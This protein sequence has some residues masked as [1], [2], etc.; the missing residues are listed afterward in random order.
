MYLEKYAEGHYRKHTAK[1]MLSD[2]SISEKYTV[3]TYG[4]CDDAKKT[5]AVGLDGKRFCQTVA[6][7]PCGGAKISAQLIRVL[8]IR[9][10]DFYYCK[11]SVKL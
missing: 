2:A 7:C 6:V 9:A 5:L 11:R 3:V 1:H 4:V 10:N 8:V